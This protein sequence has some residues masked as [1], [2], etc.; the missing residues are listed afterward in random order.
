MSLV[1][2][3]EVPNLA[4][5]QLSP[6][7]KQILFTLGK[8]E[9]KVQW[10]GA[11][12][13][14]AEGVLTYPLD[15]EEGK[16]YPLVVCTHGGPQASDKLTF[17]SWSQYRPVLA[18]R[19]YAI[20]QPNYRGSTGYGNAFLRDMVGHYFRQIHLDVMAGVDYLIQQG[21][22]GAARLG[23]VAPRTVQDER[24]IGGV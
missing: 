3:L 12:G 1:D 19:G 15:Y 16:R 14:T 2:M 23:R 13:A 21:I 7:G 24:G 9:E 11:D 10:K 4:D 6:D 17:G 22:A 20:L 18:A 5:P 8:A